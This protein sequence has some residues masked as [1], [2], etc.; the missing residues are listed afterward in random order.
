MSEEKISQ[1]FRAK[2]IDEAR[3]YLIEEIYQNELMRKKHK[4][5][6]I[7]VFCNIEYLLILIS[8]VTGCASIS[9]FASLVGIPIGI[10]I[11][12]IRSKICVITALLAKSKS[13]SIEV[14]VSKALIDSNI[15][16]DEFVLINKVL[17]E[18]YD[19]KEKI[20]NFNNKW[21]FKL[22]IK[23]CYQIV[24]SVEKIQKVKIQKL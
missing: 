20:K 13:N 1:E 12:A 6:C 7:G 23:Q 19:N 14:L 3:N 21:N 9:A 15:S 10:T 17:K 4:K 18:F 8:A 2:N 5:L 22:Y 11:S 24:W 16:H